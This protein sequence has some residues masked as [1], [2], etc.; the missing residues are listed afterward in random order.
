MEIH[1]IDSQC[2]TIETTDFKND[3]IAYHFDSGRYFYREH[4]H[5]H[6]RDHFDY[7]LYPTL[8]DVI[9]FIWKEEL[10]HD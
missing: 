6:R 7:K 9:N 5:T 1:E 3:E 8:G 2:Y 4:M 10:G